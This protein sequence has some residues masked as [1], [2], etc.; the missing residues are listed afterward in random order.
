[1]QG[2]Y[3][4]QATSQYNPYESFDHPSSYA[5]PLRGRGIYQT[6]GG[7]NEDFTILPTVETKKIF[8]GHIGQP[9][10]PVVPATGVYQAD[11][12]DETDNF[13]I[14]LTECVPNRYFSVG[15]VLSCPKCRKKFT[16]EHH[17][18]LL[19]HMEECDLSL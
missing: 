17:L 14:D 9:K 6:D 1:M 7:M 5:M 4:T 18:D 15:D 16:R 13:R 12:F 2:A 10:N 8:G 3:P 19:E 11:G